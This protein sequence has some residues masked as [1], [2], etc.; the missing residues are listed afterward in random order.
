[1]QA[2]TECE[3]LLKGGCTGEEER[4]KE[5]ASSEEWDG[6]GRGKGGWG[7]SLPWREGR[8]WEWE[9]VVS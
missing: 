4:E 8:Y 2:E 9:E 1:M 6:T 5:A 3:V 7:G